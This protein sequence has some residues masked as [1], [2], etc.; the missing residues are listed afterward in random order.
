M[1]K[2]YKKNIGF[3]LAE[4]IVVLFI[5]ILILVVI[6]GVYVYGQRIY[7][8]GENS[9][10]ITQNSR[11][12][13][14]RLT[15]EI[16]QATEIVTNL[17]ADE[18]SASGIGE[19]EF[20]DGH[21]KSISEVD[22]AQG[23]LAPN[24]ITLA[25]TAS[26]SDDFYNEMF[27]RIIEGTGTGQFRKIIDYAT[28]TVKIATID[29][30]WITQPD[31]S[32]RYKIGSEYYYI[33]YYLDGQS[34]KREIKSYYFGSDP[35]IETYV[36]WNVVDAGGNPANSLVFEDELTGEYIDELKIWSPSLGFIVLS[37]KFKKDQQKF[38]LFSQVTIRNL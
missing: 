23:S 35:N 20:A 3:S 17:P 13:F 6:Y 1:V 22:F 24:Q 5:A 14:E 16:R 27:I 8:S 26:N 37:G 30:D 29:H 11:L 15:R 38:N 12:I 10:E 31:A 18:A 21:L 33:R 19:I 34:L 32:S 28:T 25:A 36:R 2:F 4:V 7:R 9:T